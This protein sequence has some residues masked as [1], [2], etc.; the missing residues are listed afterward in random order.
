[1]TTDSG[2]G[3]VHVAPAFGEVDYGVLLPA[4]GPRSSTASPPTAR[5]PTRLQWAAAGS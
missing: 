5:S 2:T 3:I 4:A 1:V